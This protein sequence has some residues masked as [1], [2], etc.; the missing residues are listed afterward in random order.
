MIGEESTA[1][2][3]ETHRREQHHLVGDNSS[4]NH[5]DEDYHDVRGGATVNRYSTV[6][7][8]AQIV[9]IVMVTGMFAL[10]FVLIGISSATYHAVDHLTPTATVKAAY[11]SLGLPGFEGY[12]WEDVKSG[13][14]GQQVNFYAYDAPAYTS[15]IT[16][17]L[18]SNLKENFGVT[19]V[20][21]PI[22]DTGDAVDLIMQ[23]TNKWGYNNG[24]IDLLWINGENFAK[25]KNN[26]Y[27][28]GPWAK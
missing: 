12:S 4:I 20:Y 11:I 16:G 3:L 23:E 7:G 22:T 17:W 14:Q 25:L 19:V 18:A 1:E 13:A 24:T 28:Y 9:T 2:K 5:D 8:V 15:W 26:G 21:H 27:A 10:L 6:G